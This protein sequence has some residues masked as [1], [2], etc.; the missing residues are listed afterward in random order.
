VDYK[1]YLTQIVA[2]TRKVSQ[3]QSQAYPV[4]INSPTRR[5]LYDNLKGVQGLQERVRR[6]GQVAD[7]AADAAEIAAFEAQEWQSQHEMVE[8]ESHFFRGRRYRLRVIEHE[9]GSVP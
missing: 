5:A 3:P 4:P 7:S 2:L 9:S 6:H 8:G 1:A